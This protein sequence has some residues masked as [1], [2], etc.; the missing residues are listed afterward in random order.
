MFDDAVLRS[1]FACAT[2]SARL[3]AVRRSDKRTDLLRQIIVNFLPPYD[4]PQQH[5]P[6]R[7][8]KLCLLLR[9]FRV[10]DIGNDGPSS[11]TEAD[12]SRGRVVG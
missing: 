12:G 2:T 1:F 8:A 6:T 4:V 10:L 5:D 7:F 3:A 9:L 11:V